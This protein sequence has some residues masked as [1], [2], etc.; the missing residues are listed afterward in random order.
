MKKAV[1]CIDNLSTSVTEDDLKQ[2]VAGR[3]VDVKSC[4]KSQTTKVSL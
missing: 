4:F 1:F 2:F 3:S